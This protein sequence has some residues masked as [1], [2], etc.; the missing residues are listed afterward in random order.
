MN[1]S[2]NAVKTLITARLR[3]RVETEKRQGQFLDPKDD[4]AETVRTKLHDLLDTPQFWNF[5]R[6]GH[7]HVYLSCK[8]CG[9][10]HVY[11]YRCG[12][13]WCPRCQVRI[14]NKRR[15]LIE[16]WAAKIT[17]PKHLV[18]TQKNFEILTRRRFRELSLA[19]ARLRRSKCFANVSG[20]C[21]S[22]EVTKEDHG[23]HLHTHWLI[24]ARWLDME[25][26]SVRWGKLVGQK[27]AIVK[28]KDVRNR[29]Y[30]QEVCKYA[31]KGDELAKWSPDEILQF[32]SAVRGIRMF[33]SFGSL[34]ELAPKI[35]AELGAMN[36]LPRICSCGCED[37]SFQDEANHCW[38]QA[39]QAIRNSQRERLVS[40]RLKLAAEAS[41]K[42]EQEL[43]AKPARR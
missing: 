21:V 35:R 40:F 27:F 33:A 28:I 19:C 37:F 11:D 4:F 24:N 5:S 1:P 29:E 10:E 9:K 26:V 36:P 30:L 41:A 17:Q 23:W 43:F 12:I 7:E 16:L 39:Q 38:E 32:V 22:T 2:Q 8:Q 6:C 18:L 31:V 13:K 15:D 42:A 3:A 14:S 25:K 20:G 34:R